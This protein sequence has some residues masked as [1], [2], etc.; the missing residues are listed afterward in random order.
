MLLQARNSRLASKF[1]GRWDHTHIV[2]GGSVFLEFDPYCGK[3]ISSY[4]QSKA[5]EGPDHPA[6]FPEIALEHEAQFNQLVSHLL[7]EEFF[8]LCGMHFL[9]DKFNEHVRVLPNGTAL[10]MNVR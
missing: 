6:P 9:V 5:I 4:L 7:L 10:R 1:C 2:Q 8:G 3:K